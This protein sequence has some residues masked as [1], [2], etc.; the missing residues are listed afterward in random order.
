MAAKT[1]SLSDDAGANFYVLPGNSGELRNDGAEV[2]DT[3][4]GANY[5]SNFPGL[6][7]WGVTANGIYKGF[8]GYGVTI[9]EV[10]T[11]LAFTAEAMSLVS[12]K[13]YQIDDADKDLWDR[14]E[15]T[16]DILDNAVSVAD[17]DILNIDFLF[18]KVT[19]IASYTP[20]T[21]ITATGKYFPLAVVGKGQSYNLTQTADATETT[22]FPTAQANSG[23]R[24]YQYGLKTVALEVT[25]VYDL[26]SG[27]LAAL[28]ARAET[29]IEVNPDGT[30][31]SVCRGFYRLITE[32]QS[33]D[34]GALE[35]ETVNFSLS[36]PDNVP[37][38]ETPFAW[39][40]DPVTT[41][42]T[43]IQKALTSWADE[44]A[45]DVQYL[46]DG[47]A[48][49]KGSCIVTEISLAGGLETMHE[50]NVGVQGTGAI[51]VV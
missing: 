47:V 14:N 46:S 24:T 4:F 17:A 29:I 36:V 28:L 25:G 45:L 22:D 8:A 30:D 44:S 5:R 21:P 51:T 33:G 43:A 40:H 35:E 19:F 18:G 13:T 49:V 37:A 41:L 10:G 1:I 34:V 6:I 7:N 39:K 31:M 42:N 12:G 50:F 16:M 3:I 26:S 27:F 20:T 38:I 23:R 9:K 48:G 32:G 2:E 11:A 15:P